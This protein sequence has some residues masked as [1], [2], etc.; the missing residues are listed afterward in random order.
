M[1]FVLSVIVIAIVFYNI[2]NEEV[3]NKK[4]ILCTLYGLLL[5]LIYISLSIYDFPVADLERYKYSYEK[6]SY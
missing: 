5:I 6:Y 3:K 4:I 1:F 2:I